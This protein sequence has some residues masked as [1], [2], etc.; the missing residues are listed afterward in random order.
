MAVAKKYSTLINKTEVEINK[1]EKAFRVEEAEQQLNQ[2]LL[3]TRRSLAILKRAVVSAKSAYPLDA[4][5]I[6]RAEE[7]VEAKERAVSKLEG[8]LAEMF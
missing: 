3:S 8:Y 5:T 2:D 1:E 6:I 7:E 4:Q